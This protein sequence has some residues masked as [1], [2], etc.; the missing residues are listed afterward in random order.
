MSQTPA[1]LVPSEAPRPRALVCLPT[2]NEAENVVAMVREVLA[3]DACIEV[4][5]VDDGSPDGTGDLVEAERASEPRVHLLRRAGKLG[6]GTAYLA[7]FEYGLANGFAHILTMDCDFSHK[8][9]YL[10]DL[11]AG[12]ADHDVMIGSRYIPGGGIANWPIHRR[13]LSRFANFYTRL[14][15]RLPVN[16]C[17]SGFRCYSREVLETI[18]TGA[19]QSS[20]YSFLEEMV[21]RVHR[22]G[23]LVGETPILFEDRIAGASKINRAEIFRAAFH[24]LQTALSPPPRAKRR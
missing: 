13:F 9:S 16:D 18:D 20:G 1:S 2:Y 3:Q 12:M 19:I 17:T 15:L 4:L 8:P 5:V 11:L 14:F 22:A 23:F 24:V 7:G 6:L 21:F 10:P